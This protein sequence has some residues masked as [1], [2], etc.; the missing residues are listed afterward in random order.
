MDNNHNY[1]VIMAGGIG[2]RFWPYSCTAKP[3]QF[4]DFFGTGRTLLQLTYDR[5]SK[6]VP[7]DHIIISTNKAY[8]Q[9][10]CEQ[11][12]DIDPTLILHEPAYKRTAPSMALAAYHLRDLDPEANIV[13]APADQLILQ[14]DHFSDDICEALEYTAQQP[15]LVTIGI[16]P[17]HPE[18]RYGYIQIGEEGTS[19]FHKIKTFTEK[20]Q[21]EF[22]RIFVD[23]GEFYW[24]TGLFI[25]KADTIIT[26]MHE[27]LPEMTSHFDAIFEG[28]PTRDARRAELYRRYESFPSISVDYA[29]IEKATN[30][31]MQVGT[32]GWTDLGR[33]EDIYHGARKDA[34]GNASRY[35]NA[36]FYNSSNNLVLVPKDKVVILQDLDGYLVNAT[37]DVIIICKRDEDDIRKFRNDIMM[38]YGEK[39]M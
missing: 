23:S 27:L 30:M 11:L 13:M 37:D 7:K 35:P 38:K 4:I 5:F 24:N 32:F 34:Q 10:V 16:R 15:H 36:E 25:W 21:I 17:T 12:P 20:P 33:W 8:S 22:A 3:K 9:L 31:Y 28:H 6:I 29:V 26:A 39:M 2:S 19:D 1:C 18:T 14:E